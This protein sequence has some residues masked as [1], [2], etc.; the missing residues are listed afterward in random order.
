VSDTIARTFFSD[1]PVGIITAFIGAP[2]FIWLIHKRGEV[3]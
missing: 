2:F 1:L 3:T